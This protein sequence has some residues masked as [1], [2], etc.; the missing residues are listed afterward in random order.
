M[1][2]GNSY[3]LIYQNTGDFF[4]KGILLKNIYNTQNDLTLF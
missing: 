2:A 3:I 1:T 4:K